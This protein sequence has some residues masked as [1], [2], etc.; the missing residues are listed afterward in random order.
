MTL[1]P[2]NRR[3]GL[4]GIS[5]GRQSIMPVEKPKDFKY[6][7]KRL[8]KFFKDEKKGLIITFLLI[9]IYSFLNLM[10]PY[11][12]GK[13]VDA[14]APRVNMVNFRDLKLFVLMLLLV[15]FLS[16]GL[17]FCRNI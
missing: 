14:I 3:K 6:T 8:W 5:G 13:A 9:I 12:I 11:L 16:N 2:R 1:D 17:L 10:T 15:Y 7:L 4:Q